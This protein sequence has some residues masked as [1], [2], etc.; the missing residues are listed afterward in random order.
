MDEDE[1]P[2]IGQFCSVL[3]R[4]PNLLEMTVPIQIVHEE[5]N[6]DDNMGSDE[7]DYVTDRDSVAVQE[8]FRFGDAFVNPREGGG[9]LF[10]SRR[11]GDTGT[12]SDI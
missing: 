1:E 2:H 5:D 9:G 3:L 8:V 7:E 10:I 4:L 11:R 6:G 12:S